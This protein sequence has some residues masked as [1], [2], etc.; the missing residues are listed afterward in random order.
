M[1]A[2][3]VQETLVPMRAGRWHEV[4]ALDH[5]PTRLT[6]RGRRVLAV[7]AILLAVTIVM[8]AGSAQAQDVVE[9]SPVDV[10]WV[11]PGQTLWE[12]AATLTEPGG[13]VRVVVDELVRLNGL[14]SVDLVVGQ[15]LLIP[16]R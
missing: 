10:V 13:D 6:A 9:P 1:S 5:M 8:V 2:M 12:I 11:A 3:V 14:A 15:E 4:Q 7:V 16:I